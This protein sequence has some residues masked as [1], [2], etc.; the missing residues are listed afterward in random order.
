MET[1]SVCGKHAAEHEM[2]QN[3]AENGHTCKPI[4]DMMLSFSMSTSFQTWYYKDHSGMQKVR[5]MLM[6]CELMDAGQ[7]TRRSTSCG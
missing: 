7:F 1:S 6:R 2:E 5:F 3:S 4:G